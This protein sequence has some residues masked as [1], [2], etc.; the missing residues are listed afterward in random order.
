MQLALLHAISSHPAVLTA[1]INQNIFP[2]EHAKCLQAALHQIRFNAV[3]AE[4]GGPLKM[5]LLL[6]N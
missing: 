3:T 5:Y 1:Y 2:T 6:Y 4:S